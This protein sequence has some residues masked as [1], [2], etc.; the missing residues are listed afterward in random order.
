MSRTLA[1]TLLCL[2]CSAQAQPASRHIHVYPIER[3]YWDVRPG[4][5]LGGIVN[6]LLPGASL[7]RQRLVDDILRLNPGAFIDGDPDRLSADVRLWLPN[8]VTLPVSGRPDAEIEHF[9]WGYIKRIDP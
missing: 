4:D 2:A 6:A 1:T 8:A 5:T 3:Q 7:H 9:D